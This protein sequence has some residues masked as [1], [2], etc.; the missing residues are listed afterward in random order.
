MLLLENTCYYNFLNCKFINILSLIF[1]Q[2]NLKQE[3]RFPRNSPSRRRHINRRQGRDEDVKSN[4]VYIFAARRNSRSEQPLRGDKMYFRPIMIEARGN[5]AN[6]IG[7]LNVR[8]AASYLSLPH[9]R[10]DVRFHGVH[11]QKPGSHL[12]GITLEV[13]FN[14]CRLLCNSGYIKSR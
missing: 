7:A 2:A 9:I 12:P 5:K 8:L 14:V 13:N 11:R 4:G 6:K 1:S 3:V 10:E